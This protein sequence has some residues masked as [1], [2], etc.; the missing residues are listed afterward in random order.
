MAD[1]TLSCS[2][3]PNTSNGT[4]SFPPMA[5]AHGDPNLWNGTTLNLQGQPGTAHIT[6]LIATPT[7]LDPRGSGQQIPVSWNTPDDA[8]GAIRITVANTNP[9]QPYPP[10][11][12]TCAY[13]GDGSL[14]VTD[15]NSDQGLYKFGLYFMLNN[16]PTWTVDNDPEIQNGGL[17]SGPPQ[18]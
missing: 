11:M 2:L 16:D 8:Y 9:P 10:G 12:F 3:V 6:F 1:I 5:V 18:S 13:R 14:K 17:S 4:V 15:S 7:I